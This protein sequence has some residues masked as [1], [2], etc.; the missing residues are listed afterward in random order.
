MQM[1]SFLRP[2]AK[3]IAVALVLMTVELIVELWHPM[4]MKTVIN[5]GILKRDLS[6]VLGWGGL[7]VLV[8]LIGF[9]AGITNSFF[10]AHVSQHVGYDIRSKLFLRI[11]SF[12]VSAFN[13]FPTSTLITRITSD[14]NQ[15][16]NVVFMGLRIMPRAPLIM[17]GALIMALLID[18]KIA[19]VL[20]V[21]V[22]VCVFVLIWMMKR[23][24]ALFRAVQQQ[25]DTTNG[26]VREN[27]IGMRLIK[28]FVRHRKEISRFEASNR[29][30]M[31]RTSRALRLIEMTIPMLLL[32]MNISILFI[33]WFGNW[34]LGSN[35]VNEGDVVAIVI[36]T[37]RITATFGILSHIIM[38]LARARA[39]AGRIQEVLQAQDDGDGAIS[40]S[41]TM[42]G[43]VN[44][45]QS[46][47]ETAAGGETNP[48]LAA[49]SAASAASIEFDAVTFRY[50]GNAEPAL[51][52]ISFAVTPGETIAVMGATG[53]GKSTLFQLI[54]RLFEPEAGT[55]YL[56]GKDIR[57]WP[58]EELRS[59]IGMVP[60][61]VVL[62]TGTVADNIRWGYNAATDEEIIEAAKHAQIHETIL[63]LSDGYETIV[64][65]KGVNLSGGQKQRLSI[66][67]A[68]VRKP[69]LLLLDD[70]TSALDLKTEAKLLLALKQYACT[71]MIITQKVST[72]IQSDSILL[73]DQGRILAQ[74]SHAEL[75]ETSELYRRIVASQFGEK[76]VSSR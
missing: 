27:L 69:K 74:G 14:V 35:R 39:S 9:A 12:S 20:L 36:Y 28:A 55:I 17:V 30:L 18:V 57:S 16:Q 53:S 62:F 40:M 6:A 5:E 70:S 22:P 25:L 7:M 63:G 37:T 31:D 13:R 50:P 8:A 41:D 56:D 32:L 54:P 68:L 59:S 49:D 48:P 44:T 47:P 61:E 2:Y 38:S 15:L 10:S 26:I 34:E 60:Q 64:G 21:T 33:L 71:T 51:Y 43:A 11:Q 29:Q 19:G 75:L 66:A 73:L 4:L 45:S 72:A 58:L 23:G 67:R 24:F 42:N 52:G 46:A 3:S 1:F 76:A 65:Q